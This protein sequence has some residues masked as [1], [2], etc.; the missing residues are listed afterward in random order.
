MPESFLPAIQ[1][2]AV[3]LYWNIK[4]LVEHPNLYSTRRRNHGKGVWGL[5]PLRH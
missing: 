5:G 4:H 1:T 2:D 3:T